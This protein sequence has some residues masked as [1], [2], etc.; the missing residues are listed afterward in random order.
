MLKLTEDER[1]LILADGAKWPNSAL[2]VLAKL[3]D[4][5]TPATIQQ[6]IALDKQ[7]AGIDGEAARKLSIGVVAV[8]GRSHD[9]AASAY[10]ADIYEK[11]PERRGHIAMALT[12][13]PSSETWPL[14]VQ[15]LPVLEGAFA[16]QVLVTLAHIDQSPDKP[17]PY[18][19]VIL[20]G[21]K[22]GENGGLK[23]VDRSGKMDRQTVQPARRQM[24][25]RPGRVAKVVRRNL[26][27][28]AG[29]KAPRGI[30]R[31]Q[32]D[33]RR[34]VHL[35]DRSGRFTRQPRSK[36]PKFLPRRSAS[37]VTASARAATASVRI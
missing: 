3:P 21:L 12:Q 13:N 28:R 30:G 24:G 25:C 11:F 4:V 9:P 6:I 35:S 2:A 34:V 20:R 15:S 31:Q 37:T 26:P 23:A 27:E 36:A 14:L 16:Q 7:I 22:L 5:L 33:L 10:L 1:A 17:E 8:L 18:R 32:M 19:Q 29:R